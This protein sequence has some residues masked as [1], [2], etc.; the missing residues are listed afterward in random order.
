VPSLTDHGFEAAH[1]MWKGQM[2]RRPYRMD[3]L[4]GT[5]GIRRRY[6]EPMKRGATNVAGLVSA[7]LL[8]ALTGGVFW[9][10][11]DYGPE[12]ALRKFHRAAV[13][14]NYRELVDTV[15]PNSYRQ[16]LEDLAYMVDT[17]AR[18]GARYQ[19]KFVERRNKRVKAEVIYVHP[20][21]QMQPSVFWIVEKLPGGWRVN[22]NDTVSF[23]R[24]L[25]GVS[26]T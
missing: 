1:P 25:Y 17:Y 14:R 19:L 23:M 20:N 15:S 21:R 9:V 7:L 16:N 12:S 10:L 4:S 13:N 5:A 8:A 18:R 24:S 22:V 26:P 2:G 6:K 11:Q 3:P